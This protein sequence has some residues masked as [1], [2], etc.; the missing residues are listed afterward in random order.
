MPQQTITTDDEWLDL[1][2]GEAAIVIGRLRAISNIG[3]IIAFP[4]WSELFVAYPP[5]Q[6]PPQASLL[7]KLVH[8]EVIRTDDGV[9]LRAPIALQ[10][11]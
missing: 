2:V 9:A 7:N 10:A 6:P 1:D 3:L 11:Q 4:D 5:D 8:C